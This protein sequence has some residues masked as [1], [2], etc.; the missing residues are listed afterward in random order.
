VAL[1]DEKFDILAKP[2]VI[3]SNAKP[4]RIISNPNEPAVENTAMVDR[5]DFKSRRVSNGF[6]SL[7]WLRRPWYYL[8]R[9]LV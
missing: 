4:I 2:R 3:I 5:N 8:N 1:I 9:L 6:L 7:Y